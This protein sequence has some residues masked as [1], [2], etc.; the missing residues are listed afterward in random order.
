MGALPVFAC[1]RAE[2]DMDQESEPTETHQEADVQSDSPQERR[3]QTASVVECDIRNNQN[4]SFEI[5]R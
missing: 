2:N 4:D 1:H 3:I 5:S